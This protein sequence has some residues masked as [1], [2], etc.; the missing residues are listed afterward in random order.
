MRCIAA[1]VRELAD[2]ADALAPARAPQLLFFCITD[3]EELKAALEQRGRLASR[4]P[5]LV[6][7]DTITEADLVQAVELGAQDVVTLHSRSRLQTVATR[8]LNAA[9]LDSALSGTLASAHQY[10]DQMRAFMTGSTDAIAHV[11]EGIVV[12]VNPAWAELFGR[13]KSGELIGQPLMDLFDARGHAALKGA[14]VASAQGR[15]NGLALSAAAV[16]D[17]GRTLPLELAFERFEFDGEPAVRLRV[18]TQKRDMES[19]AQQLDAA[20]RQDITTGLLRRNSFLEAAA[21]RAAQ[22]LKAGLRAIAYL[23]PDRADELENEHGPLAA[24]EIMDAI[25]RLVQEQLQPGD[26]G[27]R[28]AGH[29]IALVVRT[30]Q[31]A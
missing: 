11:Q 27:G 31:C 1:W 20:M 22:P 12:D 14:L 25:G 4:V 28:V 2:L 29:G 5:A 9:R 6:V 19:L 17:D 13:R 30:R 24:E 26:L 16:Q 10:R 3:A 15:W 18:A 21:A 7:R 8:E 23:G